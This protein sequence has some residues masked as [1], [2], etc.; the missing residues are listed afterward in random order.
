V[1]IFINSFARIS[2]FSFSGKP[3]KQQLHSLNDGSSARAEFTD[4]Y[5][6]LFS[7]VAWEW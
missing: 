7:G 6:G 5:G 2:C 1:K 4:L 3:T